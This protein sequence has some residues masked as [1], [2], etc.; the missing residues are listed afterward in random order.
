[1]IY[2]QNCGKEEYNRC[3]ALADPLV[4]DPHFIYPGN[5]KDIDDICR[6]NIIKLI[7]IRLHVPITILCKF[8]DI[9]LF[10]RTWTQFVECT[11]RYT[12]HCFEES[13]RKVFDK[14]VENSIELVHK[15]CTSPQYQTG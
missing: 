4:K 7:L 10:R 8:F 14:A 13:K 9:I 5:L 6:Y 3:I 2:A 12:Q 1:M 11:K 15:M